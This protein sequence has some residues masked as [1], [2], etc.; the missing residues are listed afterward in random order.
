MRV[1]V[2][3]PF[4]HRVFGNRA[5]FAL[6][7]ELAGG[8]E[9]TVYAHTVAEAVEDGVR[10]LVAPA[11]FEPLRSRPIGSVS[12]GRLLWRQL[13]RGPDRALARALESAHRT[14]PF[15]AIVVFAD[16]GHW[17]GEYVRRWPGPRRPTTILCVLELLDHS[18]LLGY[19]RPWRALRQL[20]APAYPLV[21]GLEARR[22]AAFDHLTAIS[23]W[24]AELVDY[25]YGL[26]TRASLAIYD[27][28]LFRPPADG[29]ADP[30]PYIAVPTAALDR[31]TGEMVRRLH[32]AG[33]RLRTFGP[34]PVPGVPH[35][36]F[37][38][39]RSL[40]GLLASA[41]GTLFLFDYEALGLLPIESLAVGTPVVTLPRQGPRA[42]HATNPNVRFASD[43]P[44]MLAAT[45]D[46]LAAPR[47]RSTIEACVASVASYRPGPVAGRLM[48]LIARP[49][50]A[51]GTQ[52]R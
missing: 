45:R 24:T 21:H 38:D 47:S 51:L 42:E 12:M 29:P 27:D 46:L 8:H 33:V 2:V 39:D 18:F 14:A 30:P 35:E 31:R 3:T 16:E 6:A 48:P 44:E 15:D 17:I 40:V 9:V 43:L 28:R 36:G 7:R 1:A 20:A 23:Q 4:V 52:T 25:L 32:D 13:V 34:R 49:P 5:A 37:L 26:P 10:G 22:L 11:R 19:D 50:P 41:R